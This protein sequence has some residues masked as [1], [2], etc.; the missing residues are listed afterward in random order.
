MERIGNEYLTVI[1]DPLGAE[2]ASIKGSDGT[3]YLWQA[4]ARYWPRHSPLLFPFVGRLMEEAYT[5][6]GRRYAMTRHG[7]AKESGFSV[8]ANTGSS[9][10]FCLSSDGSTEEA[11][12]FLFSLAVTYALEGRSMSERIEV[13]NDGDGEMIYGAGG[14][15]GFA[16]PLEPGIAFEDY[17][18]SF[19]DA[20]GVRRRVFSSSGLDTG[21]EEPYALT[22]GKALP[23][24]H[25]LFD[26]DA[27]ILT[28]V[29]E[30]AV[31]SSSKGRRSVEVES[32][33]PWW[34]IWHSVGKDAP[35]VCI[36]PWWTLPGRDGI[37]CD[38]GERK[39]LIRL[40]PSESRVHEIRYLFT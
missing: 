1:V 29:G 17:M 7:F 4:D 27:I 6:R 11:Y 12:P 32:D 18:I 3:E 40:A 9:V 30:K 16:V 15:P 8:V 23:L 38:I 35:F 31:L 26:H 36:E 14:H 22:D 33:A 28:S 10:T 21:R 24:R 19:P 13:R 2:L 37:L 39:D 20:D 5:Y 34:G 25:S